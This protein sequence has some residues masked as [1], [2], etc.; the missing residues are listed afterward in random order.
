MVAALNHHC[1]RVPAG[2]C[3]SGYHVVLTNWAG[4]LPGSSTRKVV[5]VLAKLTLGE[6]DARAR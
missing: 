2:A 5:T 6:M 4:Q 3:A 1:M